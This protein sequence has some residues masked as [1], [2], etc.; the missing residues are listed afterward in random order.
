[1]M[2]QTY[3]YTRL[4]SIIYT[5]PVFLLVTRYVC[6]NLAQGFRR[7]L[8]TG[9]IPSRQGLFATYYASISSTTD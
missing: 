8:T 3:R 9:K 6:E 5:I 7:R 1:M 2:P 4:N